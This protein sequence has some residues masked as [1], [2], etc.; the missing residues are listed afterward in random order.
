MILTVI[1]TLLEPFKGTL[2]PKPL[3]PH[4]RSWEA[5]LAAVRAGLGV[6]SQARDEGEI[7]VE[8]VH[9]RV[10]VRGLGFRVQGLGSL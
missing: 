5:L 1:I 9:L 3:N 8:L 4:R 7:E 10:R 2:N 6:P